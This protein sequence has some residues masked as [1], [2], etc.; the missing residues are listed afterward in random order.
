MLQVFDFSTSYCPRLNESC[1]RSGKPVVVDGHNLSISAV[2]AAARY[3]AS[4]TL[5]NSPSTKSRIAKSRNVISS[6]VEAGISVYGVSTGFGGSGT[7]THVPSYQ[8]RH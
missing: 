7:C 4:V 2:T 5:D 8:R 3:H 1:H 6:K